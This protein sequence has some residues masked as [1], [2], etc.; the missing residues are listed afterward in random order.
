M[1]HSPQDDEKLL[2][3]ER[4]S[5]FNPLHCLDGWQFKEQLKD[6]NQNSVG[7]FGKQWLFMRH[8]CVGRWDYKNILALSTSCQESLTCYSNTSNLGNAWEP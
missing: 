6:R 2:A 1:L 8:Q 4:Q 5:L 3:S 7:L